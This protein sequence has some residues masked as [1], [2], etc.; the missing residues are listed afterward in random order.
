MPNRVYNFNPGPST[1]P[2]SVLEKMAGEM[3]DYKGTGMSVLETSHRS[4]EFIEIQDETKRLFVEIAGLSDDYHILFAG[5]GASMQFAMIPMNFLLDGK[6]A[7]YVNT[8]TWSTKAIKEGKM[9]GNVNVVASSE[10]KDFTYIPKNIA[11]NADACYAHI[12]SNNTIKGTQWHKFPDTGKVPLIC[13]MSSDIFCRK[14]DF[15]KFG[16]IYAGAQKNL[17]PAGVTVIAMHKDLAATAKSGVNSMLSY[18]TYIDK[19][20]MFNTPPC[21]GI[22]MVKLVLEWIKDQGGLA[23][24]EKVNDQKQ[25]LLYNFIDGSGGYFRGTTEKG[26][27]S[28]MNATMRMKSEDLEAKFIAEA[29]AVGLHGLKGHRSVGGIRV[30][31]YNAMPLAGIEKL[32]GFMEDFKKSNG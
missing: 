9:L 23:A 21:Y 17:G 3:Y 5:G 8:G 22:Y 18:G 20:S 12:T 24:V 14:L 11:F 32:V 15:N 1:L 4:K 19:D 30:S 29:K 25:K 31:M 10:D 2:L 7:D 13:D 28:W 16:M 6:S 26:D 27:R